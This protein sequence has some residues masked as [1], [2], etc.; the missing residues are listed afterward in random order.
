MIYIYT[1]VST[2]AQVKTNDSLDIQVNKCSAW[3]SYKFPGVETKIIKEEAISGSMP[4]NERPKGRVVFDSIKSGD[5]FISYKL[6][7]AFRNTEDALSIARNFKKRGVGLVLLN[8]SENDITTDSIGK[9]I[10]TILAAVAEMERETIR[11]RMKEGK[12]SRKAKGGY[13]GGVVPF[14]YRSI[15]DPNQDKGKIKVEH[16]HEQ[17]IID[18]L[19]TWIQYGKTYQ[20][21][22][23]FMATNGI[24]KNASAWCKIYKRETEGM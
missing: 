8:M 20:S 22:S 23:E 15:K 13:V 10:F 12:A 5:I 9:L 7:R 17:R 6:D 1:R 18:D 4:M 21:F 14:G 3:A 11:D 2:L 24:N 19:I 16:K